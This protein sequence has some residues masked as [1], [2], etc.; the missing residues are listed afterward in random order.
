MAITFLDACTLPAAERPVRLGEFA[1][2]FVT[3]TSTTR[4]DPT[5]LTVYFDEIEGLADKVSDLAARESS[6]CSFF[7][8]AVESAD[9]QV[10][11]DITVT[12]VH[13]DVLDALEALAKEP[14]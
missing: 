9:D 13:A 7:D 1:R 11:L 2:L 6:C 4:H 12:D 3:A 10:L 14:A 8:F 5:H